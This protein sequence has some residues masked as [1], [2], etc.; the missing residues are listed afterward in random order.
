MTAK[1]RAE[2]APVRQCGAVATLR[3][4]SGLLHMAALK[5]DVNRPA[6]SDADTTTG[7]FGRRKVSGT[8]AAPGWLRLAIPDE[9][10][11]TVRPTVMQAGLRFYDRPPAGAVVRCL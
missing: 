2:G 7:G 10:P 8:P 1:G 6:V 9:D 5:P 11:L 3:D 4:R